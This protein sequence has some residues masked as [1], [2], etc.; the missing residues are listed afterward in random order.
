MRGILAEELIPLLRGRLAGRER[1]VRSLTLRTTGIAE[2]QLPDLL[3]ELAE[4]SAAV[5]LA[6]LPGPEG[7]DLRLTVRDVSPE[8][9]V[10]LLDGAASLLRERL[11]RYR[12]AEGATDLAEI[13]LDRCRARALR[14]AAAE[15]CTGGL[16]AA[17]LT[18]IPGSSDVVLGGVVAYSNAVKTSVL[19]VAPG[20]IE[21]H[22][23]VSE[24]VAREMASGIRDRL[25]ASIGVGIT[26]VA[27]PGGGTPEKPVGL[28]WIAVDF[29]GAQRT[30]GGRFVGDRGEIRYRAT[31]AALDM[32][33]RGVEPA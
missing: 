15:S 14:V 12:Y 5:S 27:G 6:Y 31:Q 29:D 20:T 28:V 3:G 9:A 21:R 7:V 32:I 18:S 30:Y 17:R 25:D 24:S 26:G 8:D 33:R 4:G 11:G 23:A 22:G 1:V 16:L 13:V 10:A 19:G 2:S